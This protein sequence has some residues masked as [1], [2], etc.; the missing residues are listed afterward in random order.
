M[1]LSGYGVNYKGE[2]HKKAPIAAPACI[3][4]L[5]TVGH[6][7]LTGLGVAAILQFYIAL[8]FTTIIGE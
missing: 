6:A 2:L 1:R 5:P 3:Y 8:R 4:A 7:L